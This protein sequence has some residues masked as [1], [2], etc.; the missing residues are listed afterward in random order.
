MTNTSLPILGAKEA[1]ELAGIDRITFKVM[2]HR[3]EVPAPQVILACG[4]IWKRSV[5][6]K[7]IEK[8]ARDE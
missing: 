6:E 7:W 1:A 2:R 8:R 4:P 5:I 3:G